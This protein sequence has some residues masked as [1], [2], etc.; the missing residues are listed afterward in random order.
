MRYRHRSPRQA[1]MEDPTK[2]AH[3]LV[4]IWNTTKNVC[5]SV[6]CQLILYYHAH[7]SF[8]HNFPLRRMVC[9][10]ARQ[11]ASQPAIQPAARGSIKSFCDNFLWHVNTRRRGWWWMMPSM[12]C[13]TGGGLWCDNNIKFG[14]IFCLI[15]YL[16]LAAQLNPSTL[17]PIRPFMRGIT[18]C[19]EPWNTI[20][21]LI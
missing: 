18:K 7:L 3:L 5:H 21:I 8:N 20:T 12:R 4:L 19:H 9:W 6:T 14:C 2:K 1:D 11:P 16:S 10:T 17:P 13:A 15:P